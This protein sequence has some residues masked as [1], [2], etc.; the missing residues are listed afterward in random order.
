MTCWPGR[1]QQDTAARERFDLVI[2]DVLMPRMNGFELTS[3]LKRNSRTKDWPVVIVTT[4]GSDA[5]K[6]RGLDA[7]ADAYILKKDFTSDSF[8]ETIDRLLTGSGTSVR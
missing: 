1:R 2:T 8:I 5:D 7:G 4:R 3:L 6:Q